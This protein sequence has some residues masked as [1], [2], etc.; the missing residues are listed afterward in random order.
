MD[1][2]GRRLDAVIHMLDTKIRSGETNVNIYLMRATLRWIKNGNEDD[3]ADD[4]L[5]N[6]PKVQDK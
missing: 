6:E 5:K 3:N 1:K 2:I 4:W